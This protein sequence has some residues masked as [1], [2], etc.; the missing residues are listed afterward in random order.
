MLDPPLGL[1]P[2]FDEPEQQREAA[3]M[4]M[5]VFLATEIL[6]FGVLFV[7]FFI[8]RASYAGAFAQTAQQLHLGLGALNTAV[9]LTSSLTMTLADQA[10]LN[11]RRNTVLM[12]LGITALLGAVFL[13]IKGFEYRAEFREGFAAGSGSAFTSNGAHSGHAALFAHFYFAMTGLHALHLL[14]GIGAVLA[15]ALLVATNRD[16][17][18]NRIAVTGLYW[19]FIDVVWIFLFSSIYLLGSHG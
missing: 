5:W 6:F 10:F 2:Q 19:H 13:T 18:G 1:A 9:L 7:T 15:V 4:G 12:L 3:L 17:T 14:I 11:G 8:Y 16:P